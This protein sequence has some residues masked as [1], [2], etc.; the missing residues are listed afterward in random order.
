MRASPAEGAVV[1]ATAVATLAVGL[2]FAVFAGV[3]LSLFQYLSRTSRPRLVPVSPRPDRA[4]RELRNAAK[5]NLLEC[6]QLKI[7]RVDGSLYFGAVDYVKDALQDMVDEPPAPNHLLIV[8]S[9]TNFVD[10]S[11][12]ELL[13][14]EAHRLDAA[15][16]GLYL[17]SMKDPA[18]AIVH[19]GGYV[20]QMGPNHFFR[21]PKVAINEIV[22]RQLDHVR[23][24]RC[25]RY[26]FQECAD[27]KAKGGMQLPPGE[28][29]ESGA[30]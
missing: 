1:G 29:R 23:C 25:P 4:G 10:V 27:A 11:G 2:E 13:A 24:A 5:N 8:G 17:C 20:G 7:L 18:L 19:R 15:G 9:A 16:G 21:S 12:A 3:L 14:Q 30:D 28:G 26:V 22:L 6:P